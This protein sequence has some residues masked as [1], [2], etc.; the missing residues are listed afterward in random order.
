MITSPHPLAER[1]DELTVLLVEDNPADARLVREMLR[2]AD[3]PVSLTY[4]THLHEALAVLRTRGFSAVLL[5]LTRPDS[6]GLGTFDRAFAE[7]PH[8]PIVVL[9]GLGD[10]AAAARAVRQGAQDYLIKGQVSGPVLYRSIRYAVERHA[11]DTALRRSEARYRNLVEGS[12]Q[13]IL[14][15]IGGTIQLANNA[16]IG[17]LGYA[18]AADLIGRPLASIIAPEDRALLEQ[19][20]LVPGQALPASAHFEARARRRD[21]SVIWL[22]CLVTNIPWDDQAAALYTVVD[23]TRRKEAQARLLVSEERFRLLVDNTKEA[24]VIAELPSGRPLFLSRV[25][26]DI[27]GRSVEEAYATPTAWLESV[28]PEDREA[29]IAGQLEVIEGRPADTVFRVVRPDTSMRWARARTFPVADDHGHVYRLVG[30]VEDI[31][32]IR[33]TE[34]QLRQAQKME[35]IGRLAGGIAHDF[36]NLL[37]AILGYA[38]MVIQ[39]LGDA[40]PATADI[41]QILTAGQSAE[42]LTRQLLAFSR[43]QLLRPT[44][45]S[46]NDVLTRV[47]SLLRRVIGE[48]VTLRLVLAADLPLIS[49]DAGQ[50]EQV[51]LNL[52]VNARDAMPD[53]GA[54]TIATSAVELDDEYVAT[55]PHGRSGPHVVIAVTDTGTGMDTDTQQRLFEPFFTTKPA[56]KGTGLGLA[57]VHGIVNQ[58]HGSIYVY[59]E[60]GFGSTFKVYLPVTTERPASVEKPAA[61]APLRGTATILVIEDQPQVRAVACVMLRRS[62]YTV[63]EAG[64]GAEALEAARR[65]GGAIDLLLTDVVMPGM[66]GRRAANLLRQEWPGMHVLFM[67]GY[68][69]DAVEQH[70]ILEPGVA[71]LEK[72]FSAAS[73]LLAVRNALLGGG[74]HA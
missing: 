71:F 6:D 4:A 39:G 36:N 57:T 38:D 27:W 42:S 51:I 34:E 68:T 45:L 74:E 66:N 17:L 32:D 72:P 54:L 29:A 37:T 22:D 33:N 13:G 2:D 10:E 52:A 58:S 49:A 69:N 46:V 44:I 56:G 26:S 12:I 19:H 15:Q 3:G 18:G 25:W 14:I 8:A 64:D 21:G 70:G 40:H 63:I 20:A 60:L 16:V 59:S 41:Q 61:S 30:L 1:S 53:G 24:F 67:S 43:R 23:I 5:D 55:H 62:G 50:L 9:T 11:A 65:H 28:H 48:D 47:E 7:A 31:T 73:L 35:A